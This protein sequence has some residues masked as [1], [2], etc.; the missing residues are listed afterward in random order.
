MNV[1]PEWVTRV[2]DVYLEDL[3][4]LQRA[5]I[6]WEDA[7]ENLDIAI[8]LATIEGRIEGKNPEVR[9][10]VAYTELRQEHEIER[11]LRR[12]Y[13]QAKHQLALSQLEVERISMLMGLMNQPIDNGG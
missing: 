3:Q 10:A 6:E 8:Y 12:V 4:E 13:T 1:T 7:K 11:Q 9:A 2:Y 5:Y